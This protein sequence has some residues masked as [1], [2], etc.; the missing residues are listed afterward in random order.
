MS[1]HSASLWKDY[2]LENKDRLDSAVLSYVV[3]RK[4]VKKPSIGAFKA[5]S[6]PYS[7]SATISSPGPSSRSRRPSQQPA[8][9]SQPPGG[10]RR[11]TV[12]SMTAHVPVYN[13]HLPPPYTELKIPEPPSRSPSPPTEIIVGTTSFSIRSC[14]RLLFLAP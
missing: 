8:Q 6:S 2:Y 12:N 11:Q 1:G 9:S 4:T 3:P 10:S 13:E 5:E 14:L 7:S